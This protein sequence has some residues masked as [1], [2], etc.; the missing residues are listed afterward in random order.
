MSARIFQDI[1]RRQ[2]EAKKFLCVGLDPQ[3]IPP[4]L[5][6]CYSDIYAATFAFLT[7]IVD[8]TGGIAGA[9]KPNIAFYSQSPR[10]LEVLGRIIDHINENFPEVLVILDFK[11]GDIGKTNEGYINELLYYGADA[12]TIN[13][14]LGMK[15]NEPFLKLRDKGIFIL[16][17]TSNDGADEFQDREVVVSTGS[18]MPLYYYVARRVASH[19]NYNGNCGLVVGATFP[20]QLALV[21]Q[22]VGNEMPI[23]IPGIGTQGG[24]L[25]RSVEAGVNNRQQGILINASSSI[26]RASS[27]EDFA[28]AALREATSLNDQIV[29]FTLP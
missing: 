29:D 11:R 15:A 28:E 22:E 23:L 1:L 12:I 17:H 16:C 24:D 3:K 18:H 25:K 13:P 14:Y 20:E 21:R 6:N 2:Q 7:R 19:W 5:K 8:A 26:I 10:M 4:C 27:G 9:F